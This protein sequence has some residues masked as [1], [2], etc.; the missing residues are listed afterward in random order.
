MFCGLGEEERTRFRRKKKEK[1][2]KNLIAAK[3]VGIKGYFKTHKNVKYFF[4]ISAF[5]ECDR[6]LRQTFGLVFGS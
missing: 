3:L 1:K 4:R 6:F 5:F 2:R